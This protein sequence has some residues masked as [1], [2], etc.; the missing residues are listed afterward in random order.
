MLNID[1]E[2]IYSV[3]WYVVKNYPFK[4][5]LFCSICL[6]FGFIIS[7]I[8]TLILRKYKIISREQKYYNWLVKLY[9]PV[10]FVVNIMFSL[11][12]GLFWGVYEALKKDSY[13]I[14]EQV[15]NSSSQYI[16]K[17]EKSKVEF[18]ADLRSIVSDLSQNKKNVK[19][20]I[21]E[22]AK[23]YDTKYK[24]IN[25]PKNWLVSL[26]AEK[27]GERIHTLI[28]YGMLNSI[29]HTDI[30]KDLSYSEFDKLSEKLIELNPD[31][32]EKSI[33]EKIQNL[34]LLVL[35]SQFKVILKGIII[36]WG[37]LML[38]PWLEFWIYKYVM[39]RRMKKEKIKNLK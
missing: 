37:L 17:D 29:P 34:F 33:V 36:I 6:V 21:V 26:F 4:I 22:V 7:L 1:L 9:I 18:I 10:I 39:K 14:S 3:I 16:F 38:I 30:T 23:V 20:D 25:K 31:N 28:L 24:V 2:T 8:F 19:V 5:I 35:K 13:S 12:I 32:L 15:Y 27:Y 11:K